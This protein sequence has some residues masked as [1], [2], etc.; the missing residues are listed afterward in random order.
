[1]AQKQEHRA[2]QES[3]YSEK[4]LRLAARVPEKRR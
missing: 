4:T 3:N 1:V 2:K